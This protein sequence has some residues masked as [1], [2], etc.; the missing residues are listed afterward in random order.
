MA[1]EL[2]QGREEARVPSAVVDASTPEVVDT[3]AAAP[4]SGDVTLDGLDLGEKV[5]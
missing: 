1:D 2:R 4:T 3:G 5:R